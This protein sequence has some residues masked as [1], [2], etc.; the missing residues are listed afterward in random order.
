MN[1]NFPGG[2]GV[3]TSPSNAGVHVQSL[4]RELD[5]TCLQAKDQNKEQK[6]YYN[7]FDKDFKDGPHQKKILK[8]KKKEINIIQ[9]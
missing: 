9:G 3:K 5:P 8:K 6:Q 1:N 2:A 4:V 7:K